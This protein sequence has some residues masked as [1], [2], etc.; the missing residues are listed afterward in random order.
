[1]PSDRPPKE[2][3]LTAGYARALELDAERLA[4]RREVKRLLSAGDGPGALKLAEKERSLTAAIAKLRAELAAMRPRPA[5]AP[6][7]PGPS[8]EAS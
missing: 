1:M 6:L 4:V 3:E 8:P 7:L 5:G 2:T